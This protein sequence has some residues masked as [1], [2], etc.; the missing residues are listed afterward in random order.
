MRELRLQDIQ[1]MKDRGFQR[2]R[3]IQALTN[4]CRAEQET[5]TVTQWVKKLSQY[6]IFKELIKAERGLL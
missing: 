6:S 5:R 3:K 2:E 1:L 4:L